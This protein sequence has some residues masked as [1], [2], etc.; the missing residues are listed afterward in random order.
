MTTSFAV[1]RDRALGSATVISVHEG[2]V[3]VKIGGSAQITR[4]LRVV[5]GTACLRQGDT[6]LLKEADGVL[7]AQSFCSGATGGAIGATEMSSVTI[8][9][10]TGDL[11]LNKIMLIHADGSCVT[12]YDPDD[13]GFNDA[14]TAATA[15]D[16]VWLP[17]TSISGDHTL[18]D[19]VHCIGVSK[20]S[21]ELTGKITLGALTRLESCFINR[22]AND[23]SELVCIVAP[24]SSEAEVHDCRAV[25][26]QSGSGNAYAVSIEG[27]GDIRVWSSYLY[28]MSGSG[29]GY[30]AGRPGAS[31]GNG[32]FYQCR[33]IGS[34]GPLNE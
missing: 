20:F 6:V 33:I 30:G 12:E 13:T 5:G 9:Q 26:V 27:A 1:G 17:A 32:Y 28:G 2:Y 3:D 16:V 25:S 21:T 14:L 22:T 29:A 34:T 7:Y 8:V 31:L 19:G 15:G 23:S 11:C 18:T 24:P 4:G 10:S